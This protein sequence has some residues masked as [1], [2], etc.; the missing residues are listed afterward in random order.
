M[1]TVISK[2]ANFK[3]ANGHQSGREAGHGKNKVV[4]S[5]SM[6]N[7]HSAM[8]GSVPC[9][10]LNSHSNA[11]GSENFILS[12]QIHEIGILRRALVAAREGDLP[13]LQVS[14]WSA[15]WLVGWRFFYF[16]GKSFITV[17]TCLFHRRVS[18]LWYPRFVLFLSWPCKSRLHKMILNLI[19][20]YRLCKLDALTPRK[21]SNKHRLCRRCCLI[22]LDILESFVCLFFS[23][24]C[25][26]WMLFFSECKRLTV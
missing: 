9:S 5:K 25:W 6:S 4:Q 1:S 16:A 8:H 14:L 23:Q 19:E 3:S 11:T 22:W 24:N 18:T 17:Q 20:S 26:L 15:L 13:T 2:I 12:S 21:L 7:L 10:T